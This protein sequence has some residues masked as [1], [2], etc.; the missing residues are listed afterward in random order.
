MVTYKKLNKEE[1]RIICQKMVKKLWEKS[2]AFNLLLEIDKEY[3]SI[4]KRY[5][6][7]EVTDFDKKYP[8]VVKKS[9]MILYTREF[10]PS[11]DKWE[12][13]WC[14]TLFSW[15]YIKSNNVIVG[16]F[17]DEKMNDTSYVDYRNII[18]YIKEEDMALYNK[19]KDELIP[20]I[21]EIENFAESL[22]CA[23]DKIT[24]LNK[25]KMEIPEAYEIYVQRFGELTN[26]KQVPCTEKKSDFCDAVEK[27]RAQYNKK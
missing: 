25:L 3:D 5:I 27:I 10:L 6:P 22:R 21:K 1:R 18:Q 24:T 12:S 9:N 26:N 2:E 17:K 14:E 15:P 19:I 8:G 7:A 11:G 13:R 16:F 20:K 23:L 4:M